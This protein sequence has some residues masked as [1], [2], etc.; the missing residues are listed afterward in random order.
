MKTNASY[1]THV[2]INQSIGHLMQI[3]ID[4]KCV[5]V[6]FKYG[7]LIRSNELEAYKFVQ[8]GLLFYLLLPVCLCVV[9]KLLIGFDCTEK[10]S[11][12]KSSLTCLLVSFLNEKNTCVRACLC[13]IKL[14]PNSFFRWN[15]FDVSVSL[16]LAVFSFTSFWISEIRGNFVKGFRLFFI[17]RFLRKC[18][19]KACGTIQVCYTMWKSAIA[20]WFA[21]IELK[22]TVW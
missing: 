10:T 15:S 8:L 4:L 9:S 3:D 2:C 7:N 1:I 14:R 11:L 19:A 6:S 17:S 20:K 5:V 18:I 21:K 12:R 22:F 16:S 13:A